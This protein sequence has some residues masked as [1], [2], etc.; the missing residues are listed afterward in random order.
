MGMKEFL[1][2]LVLNNIY[3]NAVMLKDETAYKIL[4]DMIECKDCEK[5][6]AQIK[7][8]VDGKPTCVATV[9]LYYLRVV[10]TVNGDSH[11]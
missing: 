11:E 3:A 2:K 5:C 8:C 6:H 1:M 4:S 10:K 7:S 9:L